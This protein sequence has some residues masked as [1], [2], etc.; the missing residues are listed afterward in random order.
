MAKKQKFEKLWIHAE[1]KGELQSNTA[2][3]ARD[4]ARIAAKRARKGWKV[5]VTSTNGRT[6]FM[7]CSPSSTKAYWSD[8]D[9]K[10]HAICTMT[11]AFKKRVRGRS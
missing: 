11:P 3:N 4:A 1:R 7:T 5:K 6:P 2:Y 8:P 9:V 10:P